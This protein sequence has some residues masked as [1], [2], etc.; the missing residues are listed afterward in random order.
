MRLQFY[1]ESLLEFL[2][3]KNSHIVG[4]KAIDCIEHEDHM[5]LTAMLDT[6]TEGES[7]FSLYFDVTEMRNWDVVE[8]FD[9]L[10]IILHNWGVL[11]KLL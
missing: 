2:P 8:V 5:A 6:V 9:E 3:Q 7:T 1:Q 4:I 10:L 11:T